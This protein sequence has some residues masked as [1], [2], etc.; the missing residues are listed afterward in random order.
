MTTADSSDERRLRGSAEIDSLQEISR[1]EAHL[2]QDVERRRAMVHIMGDL[3]ESNRRLNDQRRAMIHIMGDLRDTTE[4]IRRREQELREKQEQLVQ[5]AKLATLGELTTGVAH[6]LNNPLNN[7]GLFVGNVLD[8]IRLGRW[9]EA[10][11]EHD[12]SLAML[13]VEKATEI[14]T[15]LRTFGRAAPVSRESVSINQVVERALS[16]L[17]EQFR[18]RLVEVDLQL[19]PEEPR[20]RGNAIQL[21]QV[22]MNLLTNARDAIVDA[23][24]TRVSISS[25]IVEDDRVR[26]IV[27]DTGPGIPGELQQ[28][29]FDPFYTTKDVGE[30][31]GLGLSIVYGIV[32]D[33]EGT[34]TV[35]SPPS[36]GA[37]FIVELPCEREAQND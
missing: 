28:R 34:I 5:A 18:L 8:R 17:R 16:L 21:E 26:L 29:V 3:A 1:L 25:Q 9:D 35:E 10:R 15:H 37:S 14:I 33:H 24:V 2:Q 36:G 11:I 4:E 6:E 19:A 13:Q 20:V 22:V 7:I 32:Q 31:T 30:G 27:A 12:L 23:P